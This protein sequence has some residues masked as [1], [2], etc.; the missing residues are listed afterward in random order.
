MD[1]LAVRGVAS[2]LTAGATTAVTTEET[3]GTLTVPAGRLRAAGQKLKLVAW[4]AFSANAN[5]K[6]VK[7]KLGAQI[8]ADS[9]AIAAN[10]GFWR[11]EVDVVQSG[12]DAQKYHGSIRFKTTAGTPVDAEYMTQGSLTLDAD[13]AL[14]ALVT[15][16]NGTA[17]ASDIT[18]VG[19]QIEGL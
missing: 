11:A 18:L 5:T 19:F 7:L 12:D 2:T 13:A 9:G 14:T 15:G 17:A 4:G 1:G 8:V 16:Q 6:R 3:L 10:T